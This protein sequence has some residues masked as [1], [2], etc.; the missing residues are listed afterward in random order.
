MMHRLAVII[1]NFRTPDL[2]LESL[3]SLQGQLGPADISVVVDNDSEDGSIAKIRDEVD[4]E[5]WGDAVRVIE[6]GKNGGFS[7]GNNVGIRAVEAEYYLLLNSDT[8]VRPGAIETL[9]R[10]AEDDPA[11]GLF[12]PRLEYLDGEGQVSAFRKATPLGQFQQASQLTVVSK[13][14]RRRVVP[15]GVSES[16]HEAEWVSFACVLIRRGVFERIG[17]LDEGMFMYFEDMEFS[18]RARRAGFRVIYRPEAKVVHLRGGSGDVK[19]RTADLR[20]VPGYFYASRARYFVREFGLHGLVLANLLWSCGFVLNVV[21]SFMLRR[22]VKIPEKAW[23]DIWT[24]RS[25]TPAGVRG[26]RGFRNAP[27]I[28][29]VGRAVSE[30]GGSGVE[31]SSSCR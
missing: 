20:R 3:R 30:G 29:A 12:G 1:V 19:A 26:I 14:L 22:Q 2:V 24:T 15:M 28:G 9:V 31:E 7:A 4:R 27:A 13:L 10:L 23:L 17:L 11:A 5:G 8:I 18:S 16:R 21:S 25:E 6:A